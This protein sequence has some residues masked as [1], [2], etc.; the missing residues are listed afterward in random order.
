MRESSYCQHILSSCS[1]SKESLVCVLRCIYCIH[2]YI[3]MYVCMYVYI[4]IY[5]CIC[6]CICI[7]IY[8]IHT[9]MQ[10]IQH[11][12]SGCV[13]ARE[14]IY[15]YIYIYIYI[16][17]RT[18]CTHTIT[19]VRRIIQSARPLACSCG[20]TWHRIN[21]RRCVCICICRCMCTCVDT[22]QNT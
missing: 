10:S 3:Y 21:A 17:F 14:H 12:T 20:R 5:I 19:H 6:I 11:H 22:S 2:T 1:F 8:D 4:Y 15:I 16:M 13:L 7:C 18:V 9:Q